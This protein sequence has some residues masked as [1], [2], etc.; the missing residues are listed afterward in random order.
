MTDNNNDDDK[1]KKSK[2]YETAMD[3][4]SNFDDVTPDE[5]LDNCID[6]TRKTTKLLIKTVDELKGV[7][8]AMNYITS[9]TQRA[10]TEHKKKSFH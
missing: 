10:R 7:T 4:T 2:A 8:S 5:R 3:A 1:K 9:E 6:L